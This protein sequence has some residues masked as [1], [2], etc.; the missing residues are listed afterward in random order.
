MAKRFSLRVI[1]W[2]VF[3]QPLIATM[4]MALYIFA[5]MVLQPMK[6]AHSANLWS[7]FLFIFSFGLYFAFCDLILSWGANSIVV[8]WSFKK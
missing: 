1:L 7:A 5:M 8:L 3:G 6:D 4:G 2:L